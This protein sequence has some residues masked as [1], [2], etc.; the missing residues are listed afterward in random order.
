MKKNDILTGICSAYDH[1]GRGIINVEEQYFVVPYVLRNETIQFRVLKLNKRLSYGKLESIVVS[2]KER[3]TPPC[4]YFMKCGGCHLQHMSEKEQAYLKESFVAD[5]I[6]KIAQVDC[7]VAPI[8][9]GSNI[10]YRNKAQFLV[11]FI[12]G[13]L[14]IGMYRKH[15][16]DIINIDYCLIQSEHINQV[17]RFMKH[18]LQKEKFARYIKHLLVKH[19]V[20]TNTLMLV[21]VANKE[22]MIPPIFI[23]KI[24]QEIPEIKSIQVNLNSQNTNVI[25]GKTN[26]LVYGD[27]YI[28]D[29]LDALRFRL[30]LFSFYQVNSYQ[31]KVL[32][33][34][35]IQ[36][37]NLQGNEKVVELF[38]GIGTISL[39]L[40]PYVASVQAV[41]I[42][43]DAVRDANVNKQLNSIENVK[44]VC[45]DA[46]KYSETVSDLV[47]IVVVDPPRKGLSEMAIAS[48]K[49]IG[50]SQILYISCNP[51]T[52]ARDI[53]LLKDRYVCEGVQPVDMFPFTY[54]VETVVLMSRVDK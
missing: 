4:P 36:L 21:F 30:S 34:M 13:E 23:N 9:Q 8:L 52:L 14:H 19:A 10:A 54:H 16:H 40:A 39:Y 12:H 5:N 35:A 17:L 11:Q 38:S 41:E 46:T 49:K 22:L 31:T 37:L 6:K 26:K 51:S 25:L 50:P 28:F 27:A 47:D 43:E 32:Y 42:I 29:E 45:G 33:Q 24:L 15:S 2:S 1:E 7:E 53:S 48:I 3:R 18:N 20:F 44:F